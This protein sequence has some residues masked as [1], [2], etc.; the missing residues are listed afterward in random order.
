MVEIMKETWKEMLVEP[1]E[2]E[3]KVLPSPRALRGKILVKVKGAAASVAAKVASLP[4]MQKVQSVSSPSESEDEI[5]SST[6]KEQTKSKKKT[7]IQALSN[8]GI[9]THSYHFKTLSAPEAEVPTHVFSLSERK[10]ADVHKS[11]ASRLFSHNR[12]FLMRVFPSGTRVSSSNLDPAWFWRRGVQMVALNWQSWDAGMMLNEGMFGGGDGWVVK[13]QGYRRST[14][15][16]QTQIKS[17]S[18]NTILYKT[19]D[20]CIEI[21]SAQDLP[22]PQGDNRR[23]GF[24]PYVKCELHVEEAVDRSPTTSPN[25]GKNQDGKHK[26]ITK[27]GRG[28][29][30]NFGGEV[31]QF[32]GITGVVEELSFLR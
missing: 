32:C 25:N 12:E 22:L 29:E 2:A 17:I 24:H 5:S 4:T 8:L 27:P 21:L 11:Q 19:F 28:S 13:P 31:I 10:L 16:D 30:A 15:F 18:Q 1:L 3:C 7:I 20:L 9:Y 6:S 26:I 23:S 14:S